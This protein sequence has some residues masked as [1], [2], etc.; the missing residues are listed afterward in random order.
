MKVIIKNEQKKIVLKKNLKDFIKKVIF[1]GFKEIDFNISSEINIFIVD[2]NKIKAIN[3]EHRCI[4]KVTDVLSFPMVDMLEGSI[5][6]DEGDYDLDTQNLFLGDIII[7][8]E[9]AL[10]QAELYGHSFERELSFLVL[11]GLLHL[12]GFDHQDE[13]SEK[14]MM[15]LQE[16]I[17]IKLGLG[18]L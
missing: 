7:S 1:S 6:S 14:T 15:E 17:L 12:L 16:N 2:N 11:H 9:K 10:E 3:C 8:A 13:K 4:D 18:R 5:N